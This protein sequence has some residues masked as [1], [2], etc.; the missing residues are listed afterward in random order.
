MGSSPGRTWRP[1]RRA[2]SSSIRS[3]QASRPSGAD[4]LAGPGW[5]CWIGSSVVHGPRAVGDPRHALR[6]A[7][8]GTNIDD[9]WGYPWLWESEAD[10]S[11]PSPW[12]ESPAAMPAIDGD[13][14]RPVERADPQRAFQYKPML[15]PL[16]REITRRSGASTGMCSSW[17]GPIGRTTLRCSTRSSIRRSSFRFTSTGTR[18]IPPASHL[19]SSCGSGS[20]R[21][22]G[23]GR[24]ARTP[25]NG[26]GSASSSWRTMTSG[27]RS[28]RG[29]RWTTPTA[30]TR[31]ASPSI[32]M[33]SSPTPTGASGLPSSTPGRLRASQNIRLGGACG[34]TTWTRSFALMGRTE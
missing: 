7:G 18:T 5:R 29:R 8:V 25:T 16:Y 11:A 34:T 15:E 20:A 10:R 13:R 17:K 30:L 31:S 19:I 27:G 14:V 6:R 33:R 22:F 1:S 2:G 23:T 26:T 24:R 3:L 28:G 12:R 9:S 32:G 21:P 4:D